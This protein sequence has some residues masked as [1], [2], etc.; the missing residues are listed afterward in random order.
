MDVQQQ[1]IAQVFGWYSVILLSILELALFIF[2]IKEKEG[3]IK[4][5][6]TFV[7]Y[8]PILAFNILILVYYI[9]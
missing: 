3:W 5:L 2:S 7:I 4:N 9:K 8:L 6:I 1:I